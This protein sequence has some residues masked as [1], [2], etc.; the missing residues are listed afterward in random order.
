MTSSTA[1]SPSG[2]GIKVI[3]LS[4]SATPSLPAFTHTRNEWR[5]ERRAAL[6]DQE[7][8]DRVRSRVKS[9]SEKFRGDDVPQFEV[10]LR[11]KALR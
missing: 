1:K 2:D 11:S 5:A 4:K 7:D 8:F 3:H 9:V 10:I 6:Q